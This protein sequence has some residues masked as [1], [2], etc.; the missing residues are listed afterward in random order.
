MRG[1]GEPAGILGDWKR[2]KTSE[3]KVTKEYHFEHTS[4]DLGK[5]ARA[6]AAAERLADAKGLKGMAYEIG[7][8][9]RLAGLVFD[10]ERF[11]VVNSQKFSEYFK[12]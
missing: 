5:I 9:M 2:Q 8:A 7:I 4:E 6:E 10:G 1:A 12:P 3:G 11:C